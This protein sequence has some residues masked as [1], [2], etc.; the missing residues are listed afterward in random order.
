MLSHNG[1]IHELNP[2]NSSTRQRSIQE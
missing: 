2:L 1:E